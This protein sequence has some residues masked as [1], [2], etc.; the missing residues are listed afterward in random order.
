M[1]FSSYFIKN[2]NSYAENLLNILYYWFSLRVRVNI[3]HPSVLYTE[4]KSNERMIIYHQIPFPN[5]EIC[6]NI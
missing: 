2:L 1:K 6:T 5:L 4:K 3:R